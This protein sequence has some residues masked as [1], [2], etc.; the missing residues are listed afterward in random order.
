MDWSSTMSHDPKSSG[1]RLKGER[2][3]FS[4][5]DEFDARLDPMLLMDELD[6]YGW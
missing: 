3:C 2:I 4:G 5:E 6:G 1:S